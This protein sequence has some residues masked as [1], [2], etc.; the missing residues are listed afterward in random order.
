MAH[1]ILISDDTFLNEHI[2]LN[3]SALAG[4]KLAVVADIEKFKTLVEIDPTYEVVVSMTTL[5]NREIIKVVSKL[6][7]ELLPDSQVFFM[8]HHNEQMPSRQFHSIKNHN[9]VIQ[10]VKLAGEVLKIKLAQTPAQEEADYFPIPL[11]LLENVKTA[12]Q[13]LWQPN[14]SGDSTDYLK[15]AVQGEPLGNKVNLWK[16]NKIKTVYVKKEHKAQVITAMTMELTKHLIG[17]MENA[18][19]QNAEDALNTQNSLMDQAGE[20][21]G[22]VFADP[23][24]FAALAPEVKEQLSKTAHATEKLVK[25]VV[26]T[27]PSNLNKLVEIFQKGKMTYVQKHSL[28]VN[29]LCVEMIRKE[30]WF[31]SQVYSTL[32]L[33]TFF[34]DIVLVPIYIKYPNAPEDEN[35]LLSMTELNE[36]ER[37][38]VRWHP[39]I[40]A[41]MV[42]Q[43]PNMPPGLD[44]LILQHH[45]NISGILDEKIPQD[46]ISPLSKLVFVS[47]LLAKELLSS[48]I[49]LSEDQR[50]S[51]LQ[52][53][54]GK[55]GKRSYQ[56]LLK[57]LYE[58]S[59]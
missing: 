10:L 35:A 36:N 42:S 56:K 58:I 13:D 19:E 18:P 6:C 21:F 34:H 32:S 24:T 3:M 7:M 31:T 28:L 30:T 15:L 53:I 14:L 8:G 43:M 25:S 12:N 54:E 38:L 26:K 2:K 23:E 48:K 5:G 44:Q 29:F 4:C 16:G 37:N 9:D 11:F 22:Q 1:G 52:Q 50:K 57:P 51:V 41:S 40:V 47:E 46:E 55:L 27:V 20:L 49:P 17:K 59:L 33:V 45:G 39:K